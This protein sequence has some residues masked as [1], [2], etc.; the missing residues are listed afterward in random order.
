MPFFSCVDWNGKLLSAQYPFT[1]PIWSK[2][3]CLVLKQAACFCVSIPKAFTTAVSC[4][5]QEE[6]GQGGAH[7]LMTQSPSLGQHPQVAASQQTHPQAA[8][9]PPSHALSLCPL[10]SLLLLSLL[11]FQQVLHWVLPASAGLQAP[12]C[13]SLGSGGADPAVWLQG[14]LLLL[15]TC[16]LCYFCFFYTF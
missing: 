14:V 2:P 13:I 15:A 7:P 10:A 9:A 12:L 1:N 6:A 5:C 16:L 8:P 4:R 11:W 3:L